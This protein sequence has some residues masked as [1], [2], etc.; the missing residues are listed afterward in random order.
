[1]RMQDRRTFARK[2][3]ALSLECVSNNGTV[4]CGPRGRM[5]LEV[6]DLSLGGLSA[7]VDHPIV[8]DS[9]MA[10]F[11]PPQHPCQGALASGKVIRS[12]RTGEGYRISVEFDR[13]PSARG[14]MPYTD[15]AL[16]NVC[17]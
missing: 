1:M 3:V 8:K 11:F 6:Q 16:S 9:R 7:Y 12:E 14:R 2:R 10:V 15:R 4:D 17:A 5:R 13:F